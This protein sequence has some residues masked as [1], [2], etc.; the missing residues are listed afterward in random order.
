MSSLCNIPVDTLNED[1]EPSGF[2]SFGYDKREK[3]AF[4]DSENNRLQLFEKPDNHDTL[5]TVLPRN[6]R[7]NAANANKMVHRKIDNKPFRMFSTDI[8]DDFYINHVSWGAN[9]IV[10]I[11]CVNNV[12]FWNAVS[13]DI[14]HFTTDEPG[15]FITSVSWLPISTAEVIAIGMNDSTI[16]LYDVEKQIKIR[17]FSG[18][19]GRVASL[20][21]CR[22]TLASGSSDRSILQHDI[23]CPRPVYSHEGHDSEI[24]KL[25]W[26]P[27][28]STLAS[29][30]N[31]NT[32]CLWDASMT[33]QRGRNNGT[34]S[35]R[36]RFTGHTA[37]VKALDWCPLKRNLLASGGGNADQTI[38]FWDTCS[39]K[40]KNS[41]NAGSQVSS[42][43]W[44]KDAH[45][46]CTS[47]GS[48][49]NQ[50]KLWKY[51]TMELFKELDSH[52]DRVLG[53]EMSPD[54]SSVVSVSADNTVLFWNVFGKRRNTRS[55]SLWGDL[56]FGMPSIR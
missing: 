42:I 13:G 9:N 12:F 34:S 24:C 27:E 3:Q 33:G 4:C 15:K 28:S 48:Y 11:A 55:A 38:K 7:D 20:A 14:Q 30:A 45:E 19:Y 18:H 36:L 10:A 29:G 51:P 21:W 31:D 56:S 54:G 43:V 49:E 37:A 35:A 17:K 53:M 39:G 6:Y 41:I 1:C 26:D 5:R 23:R 32:V 40:L 25:K 47:H 8:L 16:F 50:L 2:L 52:E 44:S 46:L 22:L